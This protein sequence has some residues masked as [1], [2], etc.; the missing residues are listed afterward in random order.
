MKYK[1]SSDSMIW[2][3]VL[4]LRA[5][6]IAAAGLESERRMFKR[7]GWLKVLANAQKVWTLGIGCVGCWAFKH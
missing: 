1:L 6:K 5:A 2:L 3:K 4:A 7:V